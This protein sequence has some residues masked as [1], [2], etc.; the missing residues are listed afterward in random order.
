MKP[1]SKKTAFTLVELLVVVAVIAVF[2]AM[3]VPALAKSGSQ[4]QRLNCVNNLKQ[5]GLGFNLWANDH[6]NRYPMSVDA[7]SG[8]PQTPATFVADPVNMAQ[9]TYMIFRG[10]SNY[11]GTPKVCVCP[12]DFRSARTNFTTATWPS[13]AFTDNSAVSYFVGAYA[14]K[15]QPR[16]LLSGDR[17]IGTSPTS[18]F[19][20]NVSYSTTPGTYATLST[21][22]AFFGQLQWNTSMHAAAGNVLFSDGSV[23]QLSSPGLQNALLNSGDSNN[24]IDFPQ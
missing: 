3:L 16:M 8:G 23:E 2:T 4:S 24:G 14:N 11:L 7:A 1:S 18:S 12:A 22:Q 20:G 9:Y 10:M 6:G 5:V 19:S 13:P 17:N 15:S 21:N